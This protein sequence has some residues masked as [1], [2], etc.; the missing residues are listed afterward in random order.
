MNY[1]ATTPNKRIYNISDFYKPYYKDSLKNPVLTKSQYIEIIR[2][3]NKLIMEKIINGYNYIFPYS[4]GNI[5]I[6]KKKLVIQITKDNKIID[7]KN[8]P[9]LDIK[10]T[11]DLRKSDPIANANKTRIYHF[12]DHTDGYRMSFTWIRYTGNTN[13]IKNI[14]YYNFN[15]SIKKGKRK[16]AKVLKSGVKNEYY[17]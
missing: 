6:K 7:V 3:F 2:E 13:G 9:T 5:Y 16:L 17:L 12:N 10:A 11:M 1:I 14:N 4:L 8:R 15:A